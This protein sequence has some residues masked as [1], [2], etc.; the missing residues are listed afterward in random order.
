MKDEKD[1]GMPI[2]PEIYEEVNWIVCRRGLPDWT[3]I[4]SYMSRARLRPMS[5]SAMSHPP[6]PDCLFETTVIKPGAIVYRVPDTG[7]PQ[8]D[9]ATNWLASRY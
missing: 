1:H 3:I 8:E 7:L 2:H 6:P 4:W 5:K 9:A